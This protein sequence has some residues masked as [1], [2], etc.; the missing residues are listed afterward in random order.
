MSATGNQA[1]RWIRRAATSAA[2]AALGLAC[3]VSS[4]RADLP[5]DQEERGTY[6]ELTG[7]KE[8]ATNLDF[9]LAT[10]SSGAGSTSLEFD[11]TLEW[12][13]RVGWLLPSKKGAVSITDWI[14]DQTEEEGAVQAAGTL[15][16]TSFLAVITPRSGLQAVSQVQARS[17][18][19]AYSRD[20]RQSYHWRST[21][22][23]GLRYFHYEH[24]MQ[25]DYR[26]A[27]GSLTD[28]AFEQ[29]EST[30]IGPR[31]GAGFQYSLTSKLALSVGGG[32]ATL[33]GDTDFSNVSQT[34]FGLPSFATAFNE[35]RDI[36][37]TFSQVDLDLHL[38]YTP[39]RTLQVAGGYRIS[40]WYDVRARQPF[41]GSFE[42]ERVAFDGP[43]LSVGY[44]F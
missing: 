21:W 13:Y 10:S 5:R 30:G 11:R 12:R 1:C 2:C 37:R 20:V 41:D 9:G 35:E 3:A 40:D 29:V 25:T 16:P 27:L 44:R 31:V 17:L 6:I 38:V 28:R 15:V 19:V 7:F 42:V 43:Y 23:V 8:R 33:A 39:W 18:D 4:A 22:S 14:Y 32:I 26:A 24:R 34:N 36:R